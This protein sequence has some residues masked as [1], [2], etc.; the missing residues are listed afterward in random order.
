MLRDGDTLRTMGYL[1]GFRGDPCRD[2][3]PAYL[4]GY[5]IGSEDIR[6]LESRDRAPDD[7][8]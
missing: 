4:E 8:A 7:N 3:D 6:V 5:Q 1:D 2:T